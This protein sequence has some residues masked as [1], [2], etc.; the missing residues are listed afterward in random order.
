MVEP[1]M[2]AS[3]KQRRLT[4]R[5]VVLVLCILVLL[6]LNWAA[7]DDITTGSEQSHFWEWAI[8]FVTLGG[9]VVGVVVGLRRRR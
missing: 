5:T 7:L 9:I 4:L 6:V 1:S 8:F 3:S 2:T